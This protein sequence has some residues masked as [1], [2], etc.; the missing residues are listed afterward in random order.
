MT[1]ETSHRKSFK[2]HNDLSYIHHKIL[3]NFSDIFIIG[4]C[5][6]EK[7]NHR[8]Q[9]YN[10]FMSKSMF[11]IV[12]FYWFRSTFYQVLDLY[13]L[14]SILSVAPLFVPKHLKCCTSICSDAPYMLQVYQLRSRQKETALIV[15]PILIKRYRT[16]SKC[17]QYQNFVLH[18]ASYLPLLYRC[19]FAFDY[20]KLLIPRNDYCSLLTQ[21]D[22]RSNKQYIISSK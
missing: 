20:S 9:H 8:V 16:T 4:Q 14:R 2:N 6:C 22:S 1:A 21:G 11:L 7:E 13:Q 5:Q 17:F 3:L 10:Q 19:D 12:W 18:P 15:P